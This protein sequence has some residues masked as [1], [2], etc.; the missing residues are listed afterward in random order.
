MD[1]S[2]ID[3]NGESAKN[4]PNHSSSSP[5]VEGVSGIGEFGRR[6]LEHLIKRHMFLGNI[7][8]VDKTKAVEI[9]RLRIVSFGL[10][11][12]LDGGAKPISH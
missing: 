7:L 11:Q 5:D 9:E 10:H 4:G 1:V 8:G 6:C 3:D 12:G 2:K